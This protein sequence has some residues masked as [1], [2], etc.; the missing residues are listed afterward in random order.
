MGANP[1]DTVQPPA[2]PG[3]SSAET[4]GPQSPGSLAPLARLLLLLAETHPDEE[5]VDLQES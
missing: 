1:Q 5:R 3:S 2:D 4:A